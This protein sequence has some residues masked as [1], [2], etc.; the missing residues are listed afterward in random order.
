MTVRG[1]N[2]RHLMGPL[3]CAEGEKGGFAQLHI[4]DDRDEVAARRLQLFPGTG[5]ILLEA[6]DGSLRQHNSYVS[7]FVTSKEDIQR[8]VREGYQINH[9]FLKIDATGKAKIFARPSPNENIAGF[10]EDDGQCGVG[11][12][13][14]S[15]FKSFPHAA[16]VKGLGVKV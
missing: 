7:Q 10:L 14:F 15:L 9:L 12:S 5:P 11:G 8:A 6:L 1:G 2:V 3:E 13:G 4:I 16:R